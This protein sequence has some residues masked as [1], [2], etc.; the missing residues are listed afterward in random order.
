MT[1]PSLEATPNPF[2]SDTPPAEELTPEAALA[3]SAGR[4][5]EPETPP[6]TPETAETDP[7]TP[8]E[9]PETTETTPEKTRQP[10][11]KDLATQ[12]EAANAELAQVKAENGVTS[13][14]YKDAEAVRAELQTKL[15]ERDKD[16]VK[17]RTP[18]YNWK[19]DPEVSKPREEIVEMLSDVSAEVTPETAKIINQDL[20]LMLNGYGQARGGGAEALRA[21]RNNLIEKFGE[22][23][24]KVWEAAKAMYPKHAAAILAEK[25]NSEGYFARTLT[26]HSTRARQFREEFLQ[27]GRMTPEQIAAAP[28]STNAL[29]SAAI[30]GDEA[31]LKEVE[32]MAMQAAQATA[33]LP[34]LPVTATPQEVEAYRKS[35]LALRQF[36]DTKAFRRDVEARV[37]EAIVKKLSNENATL[38]KRV[39]AA[40]EGNRPES[41]ATTTTPAKAGSTKNLGPYEDIPNPYTQGR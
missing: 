19:D 21:F 17:A 13:Q 28:D 10:S 30:G 34:P 16:F 31:L 15:E 24:E 2:A 40:A 37:L 25:K 20:V 14:K 7:E 29:I 22:D 5:F 4:E 23:G 11:R 1:K 35:E 12:L 36:K 18:V 27:I 39:G 32:K 3:A 6:E 38:R 9:T 8:P 41:T 26:E 33:G